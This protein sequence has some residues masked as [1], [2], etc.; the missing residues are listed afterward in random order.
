MLLFGTHSCPNCKRAVE[1]LDEMKINYEEIF[2]DD[3][4]EMAEAYDIMSV[5]V[6]V[7]EGKGGEDGIVGFG[8]IRKYVLDHK[9]SVNA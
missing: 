7:P 2:A 1:F 3:N 4:P 6:L 5:P 9:E 8:P